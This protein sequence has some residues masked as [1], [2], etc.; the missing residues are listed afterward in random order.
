VAVEEDNGIGV[1]QLRDGFEGA[2]QECGDA[3][4]AAHQ[5]D[6]QAGGLGPPTPPTPPAGHGVHQHAV[7]VLADGHHQEDADEQV[8]L[9]DSIDQAAEEAPE[10]P[11][12]LVG[13]VLRPEGQAQDK[14]QIGGG[15]VGQVDFCHVQTP[16]GQEEYG[17]HEKVSQKAADADDDDP[18]G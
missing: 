15:Q 10:G 16:P 18:R 3:Q 5:P 1:V 13:D 11:V 9:D 7:A 12:E 17:Q 14:H 2:E 8:G 4:E 6:E